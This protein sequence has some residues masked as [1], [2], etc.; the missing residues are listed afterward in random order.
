MAPLLDLAMSLRFGGQRAIPLGRPHDTLASDRVALVGD[1]ARQVFSAHGSGI[2]AGMVAARM[3]VDAI[4]RGAGPA[5]YAVL[6]D[7]RVS[8][9]VGSAIAEWLNQV[10]PPRR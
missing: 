1:A 9:L 5:E 4:V 3:L 8:P 2:G 10:M 6:P 7:P